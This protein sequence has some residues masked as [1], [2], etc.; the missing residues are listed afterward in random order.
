MPYWVLD[1]VG[2]VTMATTSFKK[3]TLKGNY[4]KKKLYICI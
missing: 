3:I 1:N 4:F 2:Q